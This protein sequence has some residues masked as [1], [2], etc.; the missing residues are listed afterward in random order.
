MVY[1]TPIDQYKKGITYTSIWYTTNPLT[2]IKRALS[3]AYGIP[4]TLLRKR[5]NS[6]WYP[7]MTD[8]YKLP[9]NSYNQHRVNIPPTRKHSSFMKPD[10][11]SKLQEIANGN[12]SSYEQACNNVN[13]NAMKHKILETFNRSINSL[14]E[15]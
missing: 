15:D 7:V 12:N 5:N 14:F 2:N 4:Q 1:H 10:I 9:R 11:N 3:T 13:N 8:S 6:N